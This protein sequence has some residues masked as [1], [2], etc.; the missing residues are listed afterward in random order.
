MT[1]DETRSP[2]TIDIAIDSTQRTVLLDIKE[3]AR[4]V[5]ISLPVETALD[6]GRALRNAAHK[7]G[8]KRKVEPK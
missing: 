3:D 2:L 7:M 5:R 4:Q 1:T 8:R 6:L